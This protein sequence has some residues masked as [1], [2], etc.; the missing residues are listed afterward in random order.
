MRKV[1]AVMLA[2]CSALAGCDSES[3]ATAPADYERAKLDCQPHGG[4]KR[5]ETVLVMFR[6]DRVDAYCANRVRISRP[7]GQPAQ[8]GGA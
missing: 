4:L 6:D 5:V 8:G 3:V 7:A 1:T 2:V